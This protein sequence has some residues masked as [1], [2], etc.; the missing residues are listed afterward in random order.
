MEEYRIER[1]MRRFA[2]ERSIELEDSDKRNLE[3]IAHIFAYLCSN[4]SN[5]NKERY[6][7]YYNDTKRSL[8]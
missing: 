3:S 2:M 5:T 7:G 6:I 4:G 8:G 1:M